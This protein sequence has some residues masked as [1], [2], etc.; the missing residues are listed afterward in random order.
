V[1]T[2]PTAVM[3]D[4]VPKEELAVEADAMPRGWG[5]RFVRPSLVAVSS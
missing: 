5:G 1:M 2:A 3:P 4:L